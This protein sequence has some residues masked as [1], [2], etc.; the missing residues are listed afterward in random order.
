MPS[1]HPETPLVSPTGWIEAWRAAPGDLLYDSSG[2]P[3]PV[4]RVARE[5]PPRATELRISGPP[6]RCSTDH[7]LVLGTAW[8]SMKAWPGEAER[9]DPVVTERIALIGEIPE[10]WLEAGPPLDPW[11]Y[12]LW[13]TTGIEDAVSVPANLADRAAEMIE[14]RG[15]KVRRRTAHGKHA[16]LYVDGLLERLHRIDAFSEPV[17]LAYRRAPVEVRRDLMAGAL[18][19][20]GVFNRGLRRHVVIRSRRPEIVNALAEVATSLGWRSS[21]VHN[22]TQSLTRVL[23]DP[24]RMYLRDIDLAVARAA[25]PNKRPNEVRPAYY[26]H[27]SADIEPKEYV[28]I[29][30]EAG[31]YLIGRAMVPVRDW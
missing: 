10:D 15:L 18:D 7:D 19:G 21:A 14:A 23:I 3:T 11:T 4:A 22:S 27:A 17:A 2:K 30:T 25:A 6:I 1:I 29:H 16:Y 24:V 28:D 12:G 20:K 13:R 26:V 31:T 9:R 5:T 8:V